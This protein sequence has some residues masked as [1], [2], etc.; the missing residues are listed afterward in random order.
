VKQIRDI[1][2]KDLP[3]CAELL[4]DAYNREPW[5]NHWTV[6]TAR[7]Y[8][9]ELLRM[10]RFKGF[11]L[12]EGDRAAGAAFCHSRAWWTGDELFID[13]FYIASGMQRKGLGGKLMAAIEEYVKAEGWEGVTLLTNRHFPARDFYL[14]HGFAEAEHVLFMYKVLKE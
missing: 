3:A 2:E 5:L 12:E 11:I 14:K 7:R 13:E 10:E 9:S 8:L 1:T 6:E 4:I